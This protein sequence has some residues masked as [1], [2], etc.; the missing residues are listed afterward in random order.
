[1][2]WLLELSP[3]LQLPIVLIVLLP[4][5]GLVAWAG[6]KLVDW[7]GGLADRWVTLRHHG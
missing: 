5:A 1:M 3:W 6:L 7:L 4:P 2:G